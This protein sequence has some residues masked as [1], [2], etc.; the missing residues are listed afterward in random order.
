MTPRR[1]A[2]RASTGPRRVPITVGVTTPGDHRAGRP[3]SRPVLAAAAVV[4]V[5]MLAVAAAPAAA[6]PGRTQDAP[7]SND[8]AARIA[9]LGATANDA[10]AAL[11]SAVDRRNQVEHDLT[12]ATQA[13]AEAEA[14]TAALNVAA[15]RAQAR[16][17]Q[18]RIQVEQVAVAAY[19]DGNSLSELDLLVESKDPLDVGRAQQFLS[20]V[21]DARRRVVEQ[22]RADRI[23]AKQAAD[24]AEAER[25]RRRDRVH[26]LQ[27][28]V[29]P[30]I[31]AVTSAQARATVAHTRL[32]RWLS[33]R[34]GA[35]TP[36]LG[37]SVLT[38]AQLAAWFHSMHRTARTTVP[39]DELAGLYV[40]EGAAE[41]V[42]GDI[43]FAQ[44][45]VETGYFG[46]PDGGLVDWT[47]NNFAGIGACDS[48]AHGHVYPDAQT[49]V[50]V[51]MQYLHVYADPT[52]TVAR[53]A[54]PPV[55]PN[56]DRNFRKGQAPTWA[57]LTHTWATADGYGDAILAVYERI[58]GWVTDHQPD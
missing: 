34:N 48:C 24:A 43:A 39:I 55:D 30:A 2:A 32:N 18:S 1:R 10:D 33:I 19:M 51:Q 23:A 50:R 38:G 26:T 11:A 20:R 27:D 6:A 13:L 46:F 28:Q 41:G 36:I 29:P 9:S 47:D 22:A 7:A 56:M 54:H 42:R 14:N 31:N 5:S 17:D 4:V 52:I 35:A 45:I 49:G 57:G 15:A 16:Y 58:L 25:R 37:Q 40:S 21:D 8:P 3:R 12:L 53:F 44:S